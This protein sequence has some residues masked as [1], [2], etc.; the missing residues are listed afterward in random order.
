MKIGIITIGSELLNGLRMDTNAHWIA[1]NAILFGGEVISKTSILDKEEDI[2]I[3]LDNFLKRNIEMIIITGG[4]GPTH[5]DITAKS[6]YKYFEDTPSLDISYWEKLKDRFIKKGYDV[7]NL[8]KSQALIP[9]RGDIIPN[10]KGTA[11][12]LYFKSNNAKIVAMPGVPNEMKSMMRN[13][14]F[15]MIQKS[16]KISMHYKI[17]RTTGIYESQLFN[18]LSEHIDKYSNVNVAF[19]PSYLGVDIRISSTDKKS[20]SSLSE[21]IQSKIGDY[22]FSEDNTPL[23]EVVAK[24]LIRNKITISTAESCTGGLISDRLT[25]VP[26]VSS[27]YIGGL[28]AYSNIQKI[29]LLEVKEKTL[30][31]HGAVSEKTAIEMAVGARKRFDSDIGISTTGIAGP[32]GGSPEKPIGLVYIGFSSK[33][34]SKSYKFEFNHDRVTNK[35]ISS[36][37]ALN[38][39]RK[40]IAKLIK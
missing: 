1:K 8:N 40:N 35:M 18:I 4:L 12:G 25:N 30:L 22:I 10:S 31:D 29:N 32:D 17:L 24:R 37:V 23:E 14:V 2:F 3:A 11:R 26:G 5:D 27:V 15:P 7:S 33:T 38:I 21:T 16:S 19:L 9:T 20:Y 28:V 6:L 13:S 36:Q 34:I 39:L